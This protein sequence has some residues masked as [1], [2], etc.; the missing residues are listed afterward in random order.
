M[1]AVIVD[2]ERSRPPDTPHGVTG[3]MD[4]AYGFERQRGEVRRG[5]PAVVARA[6]VN[7]VHVA[8]NSA[9]RAPC[10]LGQKLPLRYR[11]M[12]KLQIGGRVLDEDP[13]LQRGLDLRDV[14]ADDLECLFGH[15][16]R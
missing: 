15:R 11:R 16:Q 3:E 2:A 13:A 8:E 12:P 7:V 4:L 9:A 14:P 1:R 10:R 5:P 6:H